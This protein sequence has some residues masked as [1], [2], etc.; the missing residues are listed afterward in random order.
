MVIEDEL[1]LHWRRGK[2]MEMK[3]ID[4]RTAGFEEAQWIGINCY[5]SSTIEV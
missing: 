5:Q 4:K 3:I 1:R 2:S